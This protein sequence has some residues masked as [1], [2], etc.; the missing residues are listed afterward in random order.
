MFVGEADTE[1]I[2]SYILL[3]ISPKSRKKF[4]DK[5]RVKS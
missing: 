5:V 2:T 3:L 4:L 1:L